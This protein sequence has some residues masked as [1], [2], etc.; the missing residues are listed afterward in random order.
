MKYAEA[1]TC[2]DTLIHWQDVSVIQHAP[3]DTDVCQYT[4][5]YCH[6]P[7]IGRLSTGSSILVY[8]LGISEHTFYA[9]GKTKVDGEP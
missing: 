6:R 5:S 1:R 8:R 9:V 2:V 7:S 3:I 4:L